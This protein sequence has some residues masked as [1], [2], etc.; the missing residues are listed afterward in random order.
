MFS[1]LLQ[2]GGVAKPNPVAQFL[3][4][5]L[6]FVILYFLIIKPI[7][8]KTKNDQ[9]KNILELNV[10]KIKNNN[11]LSVSEKLDEIS[12]LYAKENYVIT[13]R[14]ENQLQMIRKKKFN[15]LWALLW[16]LLWGV[17]LI[18]YIIYFVSKK[19]DIYTITLPTNEKVNLIIADEVK[20]LSDLLDKGVITNEEF[21][22]QKLKL[23]AKNNS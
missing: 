14:T 23:F 21:E 17:G 2:A 19:D 6:M 15:F 8:K 11:R 3:P 20:K 12:M 7:Q 9:I 16:T 4:F 13:L 22:L 1:I 5:I 10:I 18:V